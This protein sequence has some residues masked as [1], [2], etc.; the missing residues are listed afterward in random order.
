MR[1]PGALTREVPSKRS[2]KRRSVWNGN[3]A[4]VISKEG[5]ASVQIW[6]KGWAWHKVRCGLCGGTGQLKKR[7][8]FWFSLDNWCSIELFNSILILV[9]SVFVYCLF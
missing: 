1:L 6:R 2:Q 7:E 4:T 8:R 3:G 9:N 5:G